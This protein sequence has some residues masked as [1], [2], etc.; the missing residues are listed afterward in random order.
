MALKLDL[1]GKSSAPI[2]HTYTW[3]DTALYALGVGARADELD[4]LFEMNGPKVLPTFA[5]VPS[6]NALISISSQ[7]GANPMMILHG[8]QKVILHRP[9]PP[10]GEFQTVAEVK[11][12]YDKGKGA[13]VLV[14]ARTTDEKNEPVFDNVFSIFVRGEGGFGGDRGP[15]ALKADPPGDRDP[16][17]ET[18]EATAP[19]Q[20]LLYRLSGDLNPLHASPQ[21]AKMAGFDRPILHGLCT[22]GHAGRAVL[23]HACGGDPARFRSF[24]ARFA[25]VVFPGDTLTTRGWQLEPGRWAIQT[26]T[27]DGRT[28]LSNALAEVG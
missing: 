28:V 12:I 23:R 24:A 14:E 22:Y 21:F 19:E 27:Q 18:I 3:R 15:E 2:R 1:V 5:V 8:E 25:G 16:D 17:F 7:L 9:I 4:F 13:L 11:G 26:Q 10:N 20:A 6:F